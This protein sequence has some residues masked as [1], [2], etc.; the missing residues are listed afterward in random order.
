MLY[1]VITVIPLGTKVYISG[2]PKDYGFAIA[3]DIGSAI[4]GNKIDLYS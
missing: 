2:G 1:E 4:K 3:G